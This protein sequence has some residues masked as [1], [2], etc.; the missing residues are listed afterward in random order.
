MEVHLTKN[1]SGYKRNPPLFEVFIFDV[2]L[3]E[4]TKKTALWPEF[5]VPGR[6]FL[7]GRAKDKPNVSR[8]E[9]FKIRQKNF[10]FCE[11]GDPSRFDEPLKV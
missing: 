6:L 11:Y 1:L 8:Y 4:A 2:R 5:S 9:I 10:W 7:S 3:K